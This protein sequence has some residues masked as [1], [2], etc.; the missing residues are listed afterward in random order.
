MNKKILCLII[1]FFTFLYSDVVQGITSKPL[2]YASISEAL[3]DFAN[4]QHDLIKKARNCIAEDNIHNAVIFAKEVR[5]SYFAGPEDTV[6]EAFFELMKEMHD[7]GYT[8]EALELCEKL[9]AQFFHHIPE[10]ITLFFKEKDFI[11]DAIQLLS[12]VDIKSSL[13]QSNIYKAMIELELNKKAEQLANH[14]L[15]RSI[16]EDNISLDREFRWKLYL[17]KKV[18]FNHRDQL[19]Q[20]YITIK[21][22]P[23]FADRLSAFNYLIESGRGREAHELANKLLEIWIE[24]ENNSR[25][26]YY[27][28][29]VLKLAIKINSDYYF[30][31]LLEKYLIKNE[32]CSSQI[33]DLIKKSKLKR[34]HSDDKTNSI[35]NMLG[36]KLYLDMHYEEMCGISPSS[37]RESIKKILCKLL[38]DNEITFNILHAIALNVNQISNFSIY[39]FDDESNSLNNLSNNDNT[40]TVVGTYSKWKERIEIMQPIDDSLEFKGTLIHEMSH[41]LMDILYDNFAKPYR[42]YNNEA[43]D[44]YQKAINKIKEKLEEIKKEYDYNSLNNIQTGNKLYNQVIQSLLNVQKYDK[45]E[46]QCEYIVRYPQSIASGSYDNAKVKELMQPLADYWNEYIQPDIEIYISEHGGNSTFISESE[47]I[48]APSFFNDVSELIKEKT[49]K[50]IRKETLSLLQSEI[51]RNPLN[52]FVLIEVLK[53]EGDYDGVE[54]LKDALPNVTTW[55]NIISKNPIYYY[56][57][58]EGLEKNGQYDRIEELKKIFNTWEFLVKVLKSIFWEWY[59]EDEENKNL[60]ENEEEF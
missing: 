12:R 41:K 8:N 46:H 44:A 27:L 18:N 9:F 23:N 13:T 34:I 22:I 58:L 17:A 20:K 3:L 24:E 43:K 1:L 15:E 14:W 47:A 40:M 10:I 42:Q 16:L 59:Y 33:K 25:N 51:A 35:A 6:T 45:N 57:I 19:L 11:D 56:D 28:I 52:Y 2:G 36:S 39:L 38:K 55:Q 37:I 7:Q 30:N 4:Q 53:S 54:T 29:D 26:H 32:D 5:I 48:L 60:E 31:R 49:K 50:R 21:G